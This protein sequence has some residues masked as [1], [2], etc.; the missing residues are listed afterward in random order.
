MS[1]EELMALVDAYDA[2]K[3]SESERDAFEKR[4][5][6][7][8]AFAAE[9]ALQ[10]EIGRSIQQEDE[11]A[12]IAAT[13]ASV[14]DEESVK[15]PVKSEAKVRPLWR[16]PLAI[17]ASVAVL[18]L[19]GTYVYN[20]LSQPDLEDLLAEYQADLP[21]D[22]LNEVNEQLQGFAT[23]DKAA[24]AVIQEGLEAYHQG[25]FERALSSLTEPSGEQ[26]PEAVLYAA[27]A[28]IAD[29][30][31]ER[32]QSLLLAIDITQFEDSNEYYYLLGMARMGTGDLSESL[33]AF[34]QIESESE[35]SAKAQPYVRALEK[36]IK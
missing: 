20:Q 11:L 22:Y 35:W 32:G 7:D 3:L 18:I 27:S 25:E 28:A 30:Q 14:M 23:P 19:A 34:R 10:R 13:M 15:A 26:Y 33:A 6:E 1:D 29:Q 12:T 24:L 17:A 21:Q 5:R 36:R 2:G 8:Q 16:R 9:V 4:L 31:Y